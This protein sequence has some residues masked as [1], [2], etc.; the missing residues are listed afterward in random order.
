MCKPIRF[1]GLSSF[2]TIK[3]ILNEKGDIIPMIVEKGFHTIK[4]IL[5]NICNCQCSVTY[6]VSILLSQF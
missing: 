1:A 6:D 2:H 4:S 3:S 5:N